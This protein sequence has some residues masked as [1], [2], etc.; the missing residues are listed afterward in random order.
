MWTAILASTNTSFRASPLLYTNC[1]YRSYNLQN[2]TKLSSNVCMRLTQH[3]NFFTLYTLHINCTL[4]LHCSC[5]LTAVLNVAIVVALPC[6]PHAE[7]CH[8]PINIGHAVRLAK[9]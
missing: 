5:L 8:F 7:H 9:F 6:T 1:P 2:G 4:K 3:L